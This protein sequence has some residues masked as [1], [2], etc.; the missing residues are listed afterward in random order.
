[1]KGKKIIIGITG[2]IAA[3]KAAILVRL[4]IKKGADVNKIQIYQH[5]TIAYIISVIFLIIKFFPFIINHAF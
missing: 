1:M 3:Y 4:L 2:G 5:S